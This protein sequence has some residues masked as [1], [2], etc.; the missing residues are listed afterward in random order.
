MKHTL[1]TRL[2][3]SIAA[4]LCLAVRSTGQ[5]TY[6]FPENI[7][8]LITTR[9]G[10][11]FPYNL[12]A[13]QVTKGGVTSIVPAGCGP[14]AMAQVI[15]YHQY[16]QTV[17]TMGR[18]Y[19]WTLMF[20]K[21]KMSIENKSLESVANLIYDCGNS[22][23]TWYSQKGSSNTLS[24][25]MG[26]MRYHF[27]YTNYM[28][29]YSRNQFNTPHLDSIYR[30]L[31]FSELKAG[32]PII[33]RGYSEKER[34]GHLYIIDGCKGNK[35]HVNMGWE[36]KGDGYYTLDDLNTYN[37]EQWMLIEVADSTYHPQMTSVRLDTAGTLRQQ[38]NGDARLLTRH[39]Q[40]SGSMNE[41]DFATLR[42]ML[43]YGMLR[44]IDLK[45]TD[46]TILPDSAFYDC[47]Y[48]SHVKL[49]RYLEK[50]G[51]HSFC[52]CPNLNLIDLPEG[53]EFIGNGAFGGCIYL[54][55]LQLPSSIKTILS[56]AFNSCQMLTS[57][58]IPE[59][60]EL[61]GSYVFAHCKRLQTL[62]L[63]QSLKIIG[64]DITHDC[65]LL[66]SQK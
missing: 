12:Y 30:Q 45:E 21:Y 46:V 31:I 62:R 50:I 36:G 25:V 34:E 33:Y 55:E 64:K 39:I 15:N 17:P 10:Q 60:T 29:I 57:V 20:D 5:E 58:N 27:R 32:R 18:T 40:I 63:P 53:L 37:T 59:G 42:E 54:R 38:L 11:Q 52:L 23:F 7:K 28:S 9:W 13:P 6:R 48:L 1:N 35:V 49:P 8:P 47:F 65:P 66:E 4:L 22:A 2:L 19:D 56:N 51:H 14:I 24:A 44:T 61:L 3:L 43:Q 16:P 41:H 26:G